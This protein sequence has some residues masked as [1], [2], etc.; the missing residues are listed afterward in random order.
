MHIFAPNGGYCLVTCTSLN[1]TTMDNAKTCMVTS[2]KKIYGLAKEQ[3]KGTEKVVFS[4]E[5]QQ[6]K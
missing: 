6:Q 1:C 2:S 5:K 3:L 4:K